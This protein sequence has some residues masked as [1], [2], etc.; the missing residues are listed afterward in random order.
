MIEWYSAK[1]LNQ[2]WK[3][4]K[5]D[6]RSDFVFD[7]INH[8]DIKYS[9]D[10]ILTTLEAQ[11]RSEQY[12][13]VPLLRIEVPKN[14]HS[15]RPGTTI[16]LIDLIVLYA[17]AQQL[18]PLLDPLLSD[19]AYAYRLNPKAGEPNQPLFKDRSESE[20][21]DKMAK[22][23]DSEKN[24]GN[25]EEDEDDEPDFP[26]DWFINWIQFHTQSQ[27]ASKEHL[28]AAVTDITAYFENISLSLLRETL[29]ENLEPDK[30]EFVDRLFRVLEFWDWTPTGNLPRAIGLPQGNSISSFL[31]NL[32]L[33]NL[34]RAML[35]IVSN[36]SSKYFRYIDDIKLYTSERDEAREALV[37]LEAVLRTLNLNVQSAKTKIISAGDVHNPEIESWLEKM[38]DDEP[39]K[40]T[41]AIEFL[42]N[43]FDKDNLEIWQRPYLRCLTVLR[44]ADDSRV[45]DTALNLFLDNPSQR[46]L[47]KNFTYL[48]HFV[49]SYQYSEKIANR[50]SSEQFTFPYH[51]AFMYQLAAYSRDEAAELKD[52][53]LKDATDP[54]IHW[55]CRMAALFCLGTFALDASE[56]SIVSRIVDT[57]A[58]PQVVRAAFVVL[59]Q[60][61]G[62]ELGVVLDRITFFNAPHQDYLRRYIFRLYKSSDMKKNYLGKIKRARVNAP[63]FVH[64][65]H[66]L[67]LLKAGSN[68]AHRAVFKE[69][70]EEK[71]KD[72]EGKEWPRLLDR[73][74]KIRDSFILNN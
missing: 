48:R 37:K 13:P 69:V 42:E 73:L 60:H 18:A 39:E 9:I 14:D 26:Y 16:P 54:Q 57:E 49:T 36:D 24:E 19:S 25:E 15:V 40:V 72:C 61:S 29:K 28:F 55:F 34:D 23:K 52:L 33:L 68:Q 51:K 30:C 6:I 35:D 65:L 59:G 64:V 56:L 63:T 17:I 3:Y 58:N 44:N 8:E 67:D 2:A 32:Y 5:I 1:N 31:S 22:K 45:I 50:L 41:H 62:E 7:V 20:S 27:K 71:I 10:R 11:I 47:T 70:I 21:D 74:N 43:T 38:R 12:Y 46:L 53:A 4:A 66:Q